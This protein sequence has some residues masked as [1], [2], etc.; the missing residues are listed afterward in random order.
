MRVEFIIARRF[1][2]SKQNRAFMHVI[3]GFAIAG[4]AIGVATLIIV[5][6]VMYGYKSYIVKKMLGVQSHLLI[7]PY[8]GTM[9]RDEC[10]VKKVKSIKGVEHVSCV[11]QGQ[12]MVTYNK[13][14]DGV[15]I[16][17]VDS[18]ALEYCFKE[19]NFIRGSIVERKNDN[20]GAF[21]VVGDGIMRNALRDGTLRIKLTIPQFVETFL[22][23]I[24]RSKSYQINDYF[25]SGMMDYNNSMIFMNIEDC[26]KLFGYS[27]KVITGIEI[28]VR[29]PL[30]ISNIK[31]ELEAFF[32]DKYAVLD[33]K[34]RNGH[35]IV[36]LDAERTTM[37]I[38]L[39]I[40]VIVAT[41][42]I[43]SGLMVMVQ[44]KRREIA[45]LRTIGMSKFSVMSIFLLCSIYIGMSGTVLGVIFGCIFAKNL[46]F[47]RAIVEELFDMT[48][49]DPKIYVLTE[50]PV[51]L[52]LSS[53]A[54]IALFSIVCS[55]FASLYP[56]LSIAKISPSTV[57]KDG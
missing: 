49:F 56:S 11:V 9:L 42:N 40:I 2:F 19:G 28:M 43:F 23:I 22:G 34:K 44:D 17:G 46:H 4:I 21:F 32:K 29:D 20:T 38:I 16:K 45:I 36:A 35:L 7:Y 26:R 13:N 53:I 48:L 5:T 41:F 10:D 37:Y 12:A 57:L 25:D 27:E 15:L 18:E 33:W 39:S 51:E 6:S 47:I 31:A 8:D 54:S 1:A 3:N 52:S 24:P 50:L 14:I 30:D 55:L